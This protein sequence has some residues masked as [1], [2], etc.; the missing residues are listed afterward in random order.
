MFINSVDVYLLC[1][2]AVKNVTTFGKLVVVL[3]SSSSFLFKCIKTTTRNEL[4]R[5]GMGTIFLVYVWKIENVLE[6]LRAYVPLL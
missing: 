6:M 2:E 3:S 1:D 4:S 5:L